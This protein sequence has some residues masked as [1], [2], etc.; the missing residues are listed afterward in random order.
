MV[1]VQ[2]CIVALSLLR[3]DYLVLTQ[4]IKAIEYIDQAALF[5]NF[6][7]YLRVY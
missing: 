5:V 3:L 7:L 4:L 2:F 1:E 6:L